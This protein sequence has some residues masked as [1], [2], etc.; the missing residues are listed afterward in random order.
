MTAATGRHWRTEVIP[1]V[2]PVGWPVKDRDE[3]RGSFSGDLAKALLE[4]TA[5]FEPPTVEFDAAAVVYARK[6]DWQIREARRAEQQRL[7]ALVVPESV[8]ARVR[9]WVR[10]NWTPYRA[11]YV[12]ATA[13]VFVGSLV[14][15][16]V[17]R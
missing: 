11:A 6:L 16:V 4:D 9:R 5:P 17:T 1:A 14:T 2:D 15:W 13:G 10:D 7:D 12:A 3:G 8:R